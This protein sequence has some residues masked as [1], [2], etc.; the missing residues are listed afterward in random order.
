MNLHGQ[1]AVLTGAASGI[2]RATA[3]A[4]ARRGCHLALADIDTTGLAETAA[5][6]ATMALSLSLKHWERRSSC[7]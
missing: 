6:A 5:A 3:L 2:G 4:L 1:V 7:G